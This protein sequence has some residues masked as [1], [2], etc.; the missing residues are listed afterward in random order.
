VKNLDAPIKPFSRVPGQAAFSC[1][2][3]DSSCPPIV[4]YPAAV[5]ELL[6]ATDGSGTGRRS[7]DPRRTRAEFTRGCARK[8]SAPIGRAGCN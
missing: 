6:Q 7:I 3:A 1:H 2:S 5:P 4:S 8:R